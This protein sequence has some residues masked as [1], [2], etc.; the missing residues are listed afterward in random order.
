MNLSVNDIK[1]VV[2]SSFNSG[3]LIVQAAWKNFT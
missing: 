1:N 2:S 3:D